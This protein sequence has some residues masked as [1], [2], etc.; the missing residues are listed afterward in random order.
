MLSDI[1]LQELTCEALMTGY[2]SRGALPCNRKT[3]PPFMATRAF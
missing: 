2:F 3:L 1:V